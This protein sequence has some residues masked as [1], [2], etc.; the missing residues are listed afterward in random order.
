[1]LVGTAHQV[2]ELGYFHDLPTSGAEEFDQILGPVI[3]R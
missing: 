3:G 2:G 1:M